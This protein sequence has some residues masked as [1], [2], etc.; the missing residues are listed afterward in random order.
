MFSSATIVDVMDLFS[1]IN[2]HA[3]MNKFFIRYELGNYSGGSSKSDRVASLAN[4][5][6]KNPSLPGLLSDNLVFEVIE[7]VISQAASNPYHFDPLTNEFINFPDL[8]R[9]L[10]RDGFIIEAGK[11][12]RTFETVIDF[13]E[14]ESLLEILLKKYNLVVAH[15]HYKQAINAFNRGDWAACNSQLRSYVEDLI[16]QLSK[17]ITGS[18]PADSKLARISLAHANPPL[19]YKELNEWIGNG[20][21]YYETFWKRLHPEG[22]HPGLSDEEDSIFR[23]NLVLISTLEIL[24]R[25]EKHYH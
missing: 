18:V 3:D 13:P 2:S 6:I 12:T 22:S 15:G 4:H 5:F 11:L 17:R 1:N 25:Y 20:T 7:K 23:L 10:L 24:K 19:F 9:L 8:R 21:G 14:S 16:N